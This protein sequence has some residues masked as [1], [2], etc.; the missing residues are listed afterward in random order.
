MADLEN[1]TGSFVVPDVVIFNGVVDRHVVVCYTQLHNTTADLHVLLEV[2]QS[3]L[4]ALAGV[5]LI[6]QIEQGWAVA[7]RDTRITVIIHSSYVIRAVQL[8][9]CDFT[10]NRFGG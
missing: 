5:G 9:L 8:L 1:S 4:T 7:T 6:T 3:R 10:P 2:A